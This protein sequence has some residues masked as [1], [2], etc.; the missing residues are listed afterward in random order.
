MR[1]A[2]TPEVLGEFDV[3]TPAWLIGWTEGVTQIDEVLLRMS[4][5]LRPGGD[6]VILF[7]NP[8]AD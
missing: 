5:N 8:E 3:V 7:P 2:L 4:A 6:L 1:D